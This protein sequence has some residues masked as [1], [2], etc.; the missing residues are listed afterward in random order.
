MAHSL[1]VI[2]TRVGSIPELAQDAALLVE[3]G[4]AA[5]LARAIMGLISS[6]RQRQALIK[7]GMEL[8]KENTLETQVSKMVQDIQDWLRNP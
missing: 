2:A 5:E 8:A 4:D 1:P 3:P 6:P 7:K